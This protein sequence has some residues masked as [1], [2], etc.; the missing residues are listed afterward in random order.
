MAL[1]HTDLIMNHW[2]TTHWSVVLA[3][4]QD[5]SEK[6][7]QA[8]EQLCQAYWYPIYAYARRR[9]C[10]TPD[11]EDLTQEFF[12]HLIEKRLVARATPERGRFRT[13]LL[14]CFK[15]FHITYYHRD[16]AAKRGGQATFVSID[17]LEAEERFALEPADPLTPEMIFERN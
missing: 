17:S 14:R 13:F 3:A 4:G 9:G 12:I 6:S 15:N 16:R 1:K 8:M 11:A 10:T 7:K 5:D 2:P